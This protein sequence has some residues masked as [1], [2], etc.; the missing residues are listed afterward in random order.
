M[1]GLL[2]TRK[3]PQEFTWADVESVGLHGIRTRHPTADTAFRPLNRPCFSKTLLIQCVSER[4]HT[5]FLVGHRNCP[6]HG[7]EHQP[8]RKLILLR[9]CGPPTPPATTNA[10][11]APH[12]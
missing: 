6:N 11:T 9:R 8:A 2:S 3:S 10:A 1:H 5:G 12:R 4:V 7:A